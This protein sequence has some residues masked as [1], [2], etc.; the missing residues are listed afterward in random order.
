[1][2]GAVTHNIALANLFHMRNSHVRQSVGEEQS[3]EAGRQK[4]MV[5]NTHIDHHAET[6]QLGDHQS[7]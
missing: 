3:D 5:V 4:G 6:S 7:F 2:I 1:M